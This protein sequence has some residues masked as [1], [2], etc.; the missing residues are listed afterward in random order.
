MPPQSESHSTLT[1]WLRTLGGEQLQQLFAAR[2]DGTRAPAP[3]TLGE[4]ADRLQRTGSVVQPLERLPLPCLQ[5][6]Q[7]LAALPAPCAPESLRALLGTDPDSL[8]PVL[9]VL[10]G[11]ALV[12]PDTNG[13]LHMAPALRHAWESPLGMGPG[14][15]ELLDSH[16]ADDLRVIAT[17]LGL[18]PGT[19]RQARHDA[20]LDTYE[21]EEKL[22]ALIGS[23]P[24]AARALLQEY[25]GVGDL[26]EAA[27][28]F[29]TM[30]AGSAERWLLERALLVRREWVYESPQVPVEVIRA[31]RGPDWHAPFDPVPPAPDA[32]DLVRVAPD[33]VEREA[34]AA[35]TAFAGQAATLLAECAT[36][37]PATLKSGGIG[38]RELAKLG[39]VTGCQESVVRLVLESAYAA[40][41]LSYEGTRV[42]VTTAYDAWAARES[43]DRFALLLRAWW[44]LGLSASSSRD[45][46][47]K[48]LPALAGRPTCSG[49][50][51][52]RR[53]VLAAATTLPAGHGVRGLGVLGQL[54][55][56]HR[57]LADSA[58]QD[59]IPF[60]SVG[61]EAEL[62]GVLARGALSP[63]GAALLTGE[64]A[65]A[66]TVAARLLPAATGRARFGADLT[67]V[68]TG[69]PTIRLATLLDSLA[70]RESRSVAS[71]WRFSPASVRRALDAGQTPD[72]IEA[73]L[74][75]V[76]EVSEVSEVS[77]SPLPQPL[78]YLIA[79]V[80]RRH[81]RVRLASA[82]CVLHS[83]DT[84]LLAEI[85]AHSALSPLG[86]RRL[87]P[88]V[89]LCRTE[90]SVTLEALRGA[91]YAPVAETDDGAVSV[92]R[93]PRPRAEPPLP[94]EDLIPVAGEDPGADA[95]GRELA[96]RLLAAPDRRPYPAPMEGGPAYDS[97]TEEILD[98]YSPSLS[99]TDVRQIAYAIHEGEPLTIEYVSA[100]GARTVRTVSGIVLDAP[101]IVAHC[102]L[103][104]AERVFSISR[105][106]A[107]LPA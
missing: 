92:Q 13:D 96:E 82:A 46:D 70:D 59:E 37:P 89:L 17:A 16:T 99:L 106:H 34:S 19:R 33:E 24:K 54:V 61:H 90:A 29:T 45:E 44:L 104:D 23:A 87:A 94:L 100:S 64:P 97:D 103:R 1:R 48:A 79:D 67:A 107:I 4:L 39:K 77:G 14:L 12:W 76:C 42:L 35:A 75:R 43:A 50:R 66:H 11:L 20:I 81:G 65:A 40:G 93:V 36:R 3:L 49:C 63:L 7:A 84:A 47:G 8:A 56:W 62:L 22:L 28:A 15:A 53:G 2:P 5:A 98:G 91:G 102:H 38:A 85:A 88:T 31:L 18:N 32:A 21:D 41:L 51:A 26:A 69:E 95:A 68:V 55:S 86:L 52:A 6:A 71:V 80:A 9:D 25:A 27:G 83:E 73:D 78:S 30:S 10:T 60:A 105:I 72:A 58:P 74:L 101:H 57:P